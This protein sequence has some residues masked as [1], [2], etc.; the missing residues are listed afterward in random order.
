[1]KGIVFEGGGSAAYCHIGVWKQLKKLHKDFDYFAGSS[2]GSIIAIFT[3]AGFTAEQLEQIA[4]KME[5][6]TTNFIT[7][8]YNLIWNYGWLS[9]DFIA[10]LITEHFGNITLADFEKKY[11]KKIIITACH[12]FREIY[13]TSFADN[14]DLL[15]SEAV[16]RSCAFPYVFARRE[17]FSDGGII[18][19]FPYGY[20]SKII[21]EKNILGVYLKH[22]SE[23]APKKS[24]NILEFTMNLFNCLSTDHSLTQLNVKNIIVVNTFI[25]T[26]ETDKISEG[27][28]EGE[29]AARL[30]FRK[31]Y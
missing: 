4:T 2:S 27:I 17:G 31:K 25:K 9:T 15:L 30:F 21:G 5:M 22:R 8:C 13:F 18:N 26:F 1:M 20:L 28:A 11:N 24:K 23:C 19:N 6:P 29:S 3:A 12:D 7:G 16:A 14:K 10:N